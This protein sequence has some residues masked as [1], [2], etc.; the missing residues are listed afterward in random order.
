MD[1]IRQEI[2]EIRHQAKA[3]FEFMTAALVDVS[4]NMRDMAERITQVEG[5]MRLHDQRFDRM[6]DAV[7]RALGELPTLEQVINID[8]RLKV[9]EQKNDSA[10]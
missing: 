5:R 6:L 7:D 4:K 3:D 1:T 9:L 8:Q 2:R 10:A